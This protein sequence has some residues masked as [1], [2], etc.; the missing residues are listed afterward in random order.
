MADEVNICNQ[1]LFLLGDNKIQSLNEDSKEAE[2]CS[3]FYATARD[4]CL[5]DVKPNFALYRVKL[6]TAAATPAWGFD[7]AYALPQDYMVVTEL[8]NETL[9]DSQYRE[10]RVEGGDFLTDRFEPNIR[11]VRRIEGVESQMDAMFVKALAAYIGYEIGY[12]LTN[13]DE[14]VA[15]MFD[16][17]GVRKDDAQAIYGM[18]SSTVRLKNDQLT[19]VR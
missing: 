2:V 17:Y 5:Q 18:E 13:S 19:I 11:Y 6:T 1:A 15:S 4:A 8:D 12:T 9:Q 7:F 3:V 10:W 14:K 16:L